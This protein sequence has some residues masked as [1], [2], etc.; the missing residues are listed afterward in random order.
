MNQVT[1][2]TLNGPVALEPLFCEIT[3]KQVCWKRCNYDFDPVYVSFDVIDA[4]GNQKIPTDNI[5][6]F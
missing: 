5:R 3:G 4:D 2:N 1:I 6:T